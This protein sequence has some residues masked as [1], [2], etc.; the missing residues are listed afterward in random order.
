[1]K[2]YLDVDKTAVSSGGEVTYTVSCRNYSSVDAKDVVISDTLP[3]GLTFKS[4]SGSGTYN[5]S[6]RIISWN[7]GTV[8]GFSS[9]DS[10]VAIDSVSFIVSVQGATGSQI[11]NRA[12]VTCSNGTG[13]LSNEYPN[14]ISPIL[15]R[16]Y[17][18]IVYKPII[19]IDKDSSVTFLHGGRPGV[20]FSCV[21]KCAGSSGDNT[22]VFHL[23][24]DAQEAYINNGAYRVSYFIYDKN[25]RGITGQN[26]VT[27]GWTVSVPNYSGVHNVSIMHQKLAEGEDEHG[28]WNQRIIVQFSD[29]SL[30]DTSFED[31]SATFF[32]VQEYGNY[33]C[34]QIHRGTCYP[35]KVVCTIKPSDSSEVN[36][37]DDWSWDANAVSADTSSYGFPIT[38]DYT[39]PSPDNSGTAITSLHQKISEQATHTLSNM[40][41][42]EWDGYTWRQVFGKKINQPVSNKY[43]YVKALECLSVR[44]SGGKIS[45]YLPQNGY[46]QMKMIDLQGKVVSTVINGFLQSGNHFV[47]LDWNKFGSRVYCLQI[48]TSYGTVTKKLTVTR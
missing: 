47:K 27:N 14:V 20:R 4:C 41:V 9:E 28:K 32:H 45:Y 3:Q 25:R 11:K 13:W 23:F 18:D 33:I 8:K 40:L 44:I 39:D 17:V 12:C 48:K 38:P 7:V 16:N 34:G 35:F 5:S 31:I 2:A 29:T 43:K 10:A 19:A 42:E 15:K 46:V 6:T 1:M 22:L 26:G 21:Q 36:W 30:T 24:H 37:A